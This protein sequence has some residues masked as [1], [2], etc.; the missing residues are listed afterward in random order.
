MEDLTKQN[1]SAKLENSF[2]GILR[3]VILVV[4]SISIIGSLIFG[5]MGLSNLN[6]TPA[7]YEYKDPNI[8]ELV[9][10]I[11]KSLSE[12]P[13]PASSDEPKKDEPKKD[14]KLDKEIDKQM[15]IISEFLQR[16]KKNLNN[17]EGY[18]QI[19]TRNAQKLAFDPINET[20]IMKYAVGQTEFFEKV[21]TDKDILAILDK[22]SE[23]FDNFWRNTTDIYPNY[24]TKQDREKI[25]FE[26]SQM[27]KV[28][29]QKAS[30]ALYLY[31]AAGM[32]VTFLLIS[33]I[34]VLV[35]IERNLRV[36]PI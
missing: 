24:Y 1:L 9:N 16:Y 11:K 29:E 34:L 36:R 35:K 33:L 26:K 15:K 22:R 4:L 12:K 5:Y 27:A 13:E 30:S 21:L 28:I 10:E 31:I 20:T 6:A 2:L 17:P 14:D 7:K 3:I 32:F 19:L 25:K 18:R 23:V 8:K